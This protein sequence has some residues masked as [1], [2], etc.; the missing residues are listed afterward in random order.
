MHVQKETDADF[1]KGENEG[2]N[3]L[4]VSPQENRNDQLP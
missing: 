4:P 1:S 3:E 2:A